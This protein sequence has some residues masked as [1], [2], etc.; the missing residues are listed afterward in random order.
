MSVST[1]TTTMKGCWL[2][3]VDCHCNRTSLV[4]SSLRPCS[5]IR[6]VNVVHQEAFALP[7]DPD[8]T[9]RQMSFLNI[10]GHQLSLSSVNYSTIHPHP[11]IHPLNE[12]ISQSKLLTFL[13]T[14]TDSNQ[15]AQRTQRAGR[16][17]AH[18]GQASVGRATQGWISKLDQRDDCASTRP[19]RVTLRRQ[20]QDRSSFDDPDLSRRCLVVG[21]VRLSRFQHPFAPSTMQQRNSGDTAASPFTDPRE[22]VPSGLDRKGCTH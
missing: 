19:A 7:T 9:N 5:D 22:G 16:V 3:L 11:F 6:M 13:S 14:S 15:G 17:A 12:S 18:N 1:A 20:R 2:R 4:G 21:D 8:E 10:S